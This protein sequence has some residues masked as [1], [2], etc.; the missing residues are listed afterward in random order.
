MEAI[1]GEDC[2]RWA[3]GVAVGLDEDY[4]DAGC[5][6]LVPR[7]DHTRFWVV[8]ADPAI[9]PHFVASLIEG[10]DQWA[11]AFLWPRAGGW[12]QSARSQAHN[13]GVRNDLRQWSRH[14]RRTWHIAPFG[15]A[16][17][18]RVMTAAERF[19]SIRF[20]AKLEP[21]LPSSYPACVRQ[22]VNR[23]SARTP[24]RPVSLAEWVASCG[25][26]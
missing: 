3:S 8:P 25:R 13:E 19:L 18:L 14:P 7:R 15:P 26:L 4:P 9:W 1:P 20:R 11:T 12:P 16:A 6:R 10:L 2:L 17:V 5:L 22:A 21:V 24:A 23:F